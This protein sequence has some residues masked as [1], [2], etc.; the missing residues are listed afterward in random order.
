MLVYLSVGSS[1]VDWETG[2]RGH[3][4]S[5]DRNRSPYDGGDRIDLRLPVHV[6]GGREGK[7][8]GGGEMEGEGGRGGGGGGR[9]RERKGEMASIAT[10]YMRNFYKGERQWLCCMYRYI[11]TCRAVPVDP[12]WRPSSAT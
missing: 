8:E 5:L 9:W 3:Y 10:H 2:K 6:G 1:L 12:L 11:V 4:D 7:K